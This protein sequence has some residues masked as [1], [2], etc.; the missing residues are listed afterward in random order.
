MRQTKSLDCSLTTCPGPSLTWCPLPLTR[1]L[2]ATLCH[3]LSVHMPF[4]LA[5]NNFP[6]SS[7]G[8]TQS[9][10]LT[11]R[12]LPLTA[13]ESWGPSASPSHFTITD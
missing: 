13:P 10:A 8:P 7:G 4:P 9:S 5:G 3:L 11:C 1:L 6:S 2:L 12:T